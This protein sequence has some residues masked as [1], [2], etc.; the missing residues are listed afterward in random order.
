[1]TLAQGQRSGQAPSRAGW[2]TEGGSSPK[3]GELVR[4]LTGILPA[5]KWGIV[6]NLR[7]IINSDLDPGSTFI[8][9]SELDEH[10]FSGLDD[11]KFDALQ[12]IFNA[13]R[14]VLWVTGDSWVENPQQAM[15]VALLWT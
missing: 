2:L 8:V 6:P 1:V 11:E 3:T 12:T 14:H 13:A 9:V 7:E 5:H 4:Q 15:T 10:T